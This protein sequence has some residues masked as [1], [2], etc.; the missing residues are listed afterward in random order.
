MSVP[1]DPSIL[2]RKTNANLTSKEY[3]LVRPV[4]DDDLE[5]AGATSGA[6]GDSC[7]GALT[8]DVGDGSSSDIYV[9]VQIGG[10]IKV[11]VGGNCTAGALCMAMNGG[12]A[13]DAATGKHAF[14]IALETYVNGDIGAFLWAPSFYKT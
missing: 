10:I 8:N 5:L 14:G 4:G 9:P 7:I 13:I 6:S 2:T 12:K 11:E 3:F 1:F